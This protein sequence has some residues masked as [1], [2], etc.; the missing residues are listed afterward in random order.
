MLNQIRNRGGRSLVCH[1]LFLL[2]I[3]STS[4]AAFAVNEG[5]LAPNIEARTLDGKQF[6][7]ADEG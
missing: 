3:S 1:A 6:R 5:E 4:L 7:L 2:L